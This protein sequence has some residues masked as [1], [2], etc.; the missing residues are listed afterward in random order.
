GEADTG[1]IGAHEAILL[2]DG[3]TVAVANGGIETHPDFPRAKL[4][5]VEMAPS[6]AYLRRL[7]GQILEQHRL[8]ERWHQVSLR[9]L[10]QS[11]DG[12][13]WVGG[14]FEGTGRAPLIARHER[15]A[16]LQTVDAPGGETSALAGYVG[17]VAAHENTV[18][19]TSPRG[20]QTLGYDRVNGEMRLQH[21]L[22][23][24][25]GA[26]RGRLGVALSSG[27]GELLWLDGERRSFDLAWDNHLVAVH[28]AGSPLT[29]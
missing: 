17:S 20:G 13:V 26:V 19:F 29:V 28:T 5:I 12:A 9:H 1:G 3:E 21:T 23:D 6:L 8:P 15:G 4:N 10:A 2:A 14:Q 22:A 27:T 25:C 24:V 11:A 16:A 18:V 7:D